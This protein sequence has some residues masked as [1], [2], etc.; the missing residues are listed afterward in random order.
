MVTVRLAAEA[1]GA[2]AVKASSARPRANTEKT[3]HP[4]RAAPV[5]GTGMSGKT[6]LG[7]RPAPGRTARNLRDGAVAG[8]RFFPCATWQIGA[9]G[10]TG[11]SPTRS[12]GPA[13]RSA[14]P[15]GARGR[16]MVNAALRK[17]AM[18]RKIDTSPG[19]VRAHGSARRSIADLERD[20]GAIPVHRERG[21]LEG[22]PREYRADAVR[23]RIALVG[24]ADPGGVEAAIAVLVVVGADRIG[25]G[26]EI[27]EADDDRR[28][29]RLDRHVHDRKVAVGKA[30]GLVEQ[31][32]DDVAAAAVD[33]GDGDDEIARQ[34]GRRERRECERR[35][36]RCA[37]KE[38]PAAPRGADRSDGHGTRDSS[39]GPGS[40]AGR[41]KT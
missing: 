18:R 26:L 9:D 16:A 22:R 13:S 4:R 25:A 12:R 2:P 11:A 24:K 29:G 39:G 30:V 8:D 35:P 37:G 6:P 28:G 36:S 32:D 33:A 14:R 1:A 10:S 31:R 15:P 3:G 21:F 40:A 19:G 38:P 34:R 17:D 41:L 7:Q 5:A 20:A 23:Q 27:V